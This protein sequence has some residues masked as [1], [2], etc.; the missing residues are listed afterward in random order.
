MAKNDVLLSNFGL[1][2]IAFTIEVNVPLIYTLGN[3]FL[4]RTIPKMV[5]R[6]FDHPAAA[7][8]KLFAR[9]RKYMIYLIQLPC[10]E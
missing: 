10:E 4:G 1:K 3:F 6:G 5:D 7:H 8:S 2:I 9:H